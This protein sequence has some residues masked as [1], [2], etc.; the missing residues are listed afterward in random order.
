MLS[1][2]RCIFFN[3][4]FFLYALL[5]FHFV[6]NF[7][8][9]PNFFVCCCLLSCS[10][11]IYKHVQYSTRMCRRARYCT[12]HRHTQQTN[13]REY[14][15]IHCH[16]IQNAM[17]EHIYIMLSL[18]GLILATGQ[19]KYVQNTPILIKGTCTTRSFLYYAQFCWQG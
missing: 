19:K 16:D 10:L 5:C 1:P 11:P 17:F 13:I 14:T 4:Y 9:Y 2:Q 15:K 12:A 8:C 7:S 18:M 3:K 6:L